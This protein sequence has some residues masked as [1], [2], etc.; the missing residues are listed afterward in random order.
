LA[1][2]NSKYKFIDNGD[3]YTPFTLKALSHFTMGNGMIVS[4]LKCI[5]FI[6]EN[7]VSA[8]FLK[9]E[10]GRLPYSVFKAT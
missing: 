6:T 4:D 10:K 5:N 9:R 2:R 1:H 3:N 8:A 7:P